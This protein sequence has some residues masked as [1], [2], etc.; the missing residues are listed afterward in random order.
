M[1]FQRLRMHSTSRTAVRAAIVEPDDA[2][3][4]P[5]RHGVDPRTLYR[6]LS[7][8]T[9][10]GPRQR[11]KAY[12]EECLERSSDVEAEIPRD[13][14]D[15]EAWMMAGAERTG[16]GFRDY[17]AS[18]R[19]GEG[20]RYFKNTS[21]ALFFLR[22]IAPTKMID[23]AW[24]FG[25]LKHWRDP[26]FFA[27][28]RTYLEELGE[29]VPSQNHVAIYRR[30]LA[31]HGCDQ[32]DDLGQDLF[33]QGAIQLTLAEFADDYLPEVIGFNLGYEQPP[34]HLLITAYELNELGID[35]Y[36]FTLH[37]T[38]DNA[39]S[40]HARR[41]IEAVRAAMSLAKDEENF[42]RRMLA[43]Y[44]LNE[45]GPGAEAIIASFDIEREAVRIFQHKSVFGRLVHSD[46]CRI[47]GRPVSEWL[48]QPSNIPAFLAALQET[49]WIERHRDPKESRFWRLLESEGAK[50]FG[51]FS[52]YEQKIIR[53]WIAGD[54]VESPSCS[55]A[56]SHARGATPRLRARR[57]QEND[58]EPGGGFEGE[59]AV[60]AAIQALRTRRE[61]MD[62]LI[63]LLSPTLHSTPE[64]LLATRLFN[65]FL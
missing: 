19:A 2:E 32:W 64:G 38:V 9:G 54:V 11:A 49:G 14:L 18:R 22:S 1:P 4:S 40:G 30:L 12:L 8:G 57:Y 15:L 35:P 17:L 52:R 55:R 63:P 51:V 46:Y 27:L 44:R 59:K 62:F 28:I 25:T 39:A 47:A 7:F 37:V 61:K 53:D 31:A 20:R 42:H 3:V 13:G 36:Y 21:H 10:E 33:I 29:G 60:E 45:L 16:L 24:L 6:E 34:L 56:S 23:G 5:T 65:D 50:M 58:R 43:G 48:A 41:A 26:R